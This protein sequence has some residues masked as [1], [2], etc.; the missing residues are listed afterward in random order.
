MYY[1]LKHS[2]YFHLLYY[3]M[4]KL[5]VQSAPPW[6]SQSVTPTLNGTF[7]GHRRIDYMGHGQ[8]LAKRNFMISFNLCPS[9]SWLIISVGACRR[10]FITLQLSLLFSVALRPT[11]NDYSQ[12]R[13]TF[14]KTTYLIDFMYVSSLKDRGQ[15]VT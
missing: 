12:R 15:N 2:L 5:A 6:G 14:H 10:Y 13:L 4:L 8:L 11:D 1:E 3:E 9:C 7:L